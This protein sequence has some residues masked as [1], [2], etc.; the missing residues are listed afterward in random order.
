MWDDLSIHPGNGVA[1]ED[2]LALVASV[3]DE[4]EY[5]TGCIQRCPH[6]DPFEF[7]GTRGVEVTYSCDILEHD[8]DPMKCP[9]VLD[10]AEA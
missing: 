5:C 8:G 2:L 6:K 3:F 4:G 10:E 1:S 7:W 9:G